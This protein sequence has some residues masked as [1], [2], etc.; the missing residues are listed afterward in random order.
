LTSYFGIGQILNPLAAYYRKEYTEDIM[1]MGKSVAQA[2][3]YRTKFY[4]EFPFDF[5]YTFLILTLLIFVF[6][7][8]I[9]KEKKQAENL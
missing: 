9:N 1:Y 2:T 3:V 8:V 5:I 7:K 6:R 4:L